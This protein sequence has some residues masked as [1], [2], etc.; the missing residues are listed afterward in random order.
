MR[1]RFDELTYLAAHRLLHAT[2]QQYP[3]TSTNEKKP[4]YMRFARIDPLELFEQ[5]DAGVETGY[6]GEV[7]YNVTSR[8][9]PVYR[10]KGMECRCGRKGTYFAAESFSR[11]SRVK[12]WCASGMVTPPPRCHLNLYG[13]DDDGTE[14]MMTIDH[15]T[16]KSKGGRNTLDNLQPMCRDCNF[17]KSNTVE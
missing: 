16:P 1:D 14:F 3:G 7:S 10:R 5:M 11:D 12:D 8:R 6:V 9:L 4:T 13:M 15:I 17:E 2:E